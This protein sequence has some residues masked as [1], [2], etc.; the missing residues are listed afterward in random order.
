MPECS[1]I[2]DWASLQSRYFGFKE[3]GFGLVVHTV[4]SLKYLALNVR[5]IIVNYELQ[6]H[7]EEVIFV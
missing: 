5:T 1:H 3:Q 6:K 2:T 7:V 4:S